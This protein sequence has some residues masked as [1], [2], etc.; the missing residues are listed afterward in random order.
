MREGEEGRLLKRN[1]KVIKHGRGTPNIDE[2]IR[3]KKS[4]KVEGEEVLVSIVK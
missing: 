4:Y 3:G 1:K 2:G